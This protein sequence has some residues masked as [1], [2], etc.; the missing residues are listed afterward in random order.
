MG[1]LNR[2]EISSIIN[3]LDSACADTSKDDHGFESNA[4]WC[5]RMARE[6]LLLAALGDVSLEQ[7][8][9]VR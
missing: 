3:Y 6:K 8:D 4:T 1:T 5:I 7:F 9:A 2:F